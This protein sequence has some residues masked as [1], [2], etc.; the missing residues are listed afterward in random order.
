MVEKSPSYVTKTWLR[1]CDQFGDFDSVNGCS[2]IVIFE[3][4][5]SLYALLTYTLFVT[6]HQSNC[7]IYYTESSNVTFINRLF[8]YKGRK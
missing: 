3:Y 6:K 2:I 7:V 4:Y 5:L 1:G 8:Q